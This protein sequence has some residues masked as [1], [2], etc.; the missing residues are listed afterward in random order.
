MRGSSCSAGVAPVAG[1]AAG[2]DDGA[3]SDVGPGAHGRRLGQRTVRHKK[4][5][6]FLAAVARNGHGLVEEEGLNPREAAH[7]ALV[8][9]LRLAAGIDTRELANRLGAELVDEAA[10]ARLARLGL[11]EKHGPRLAAT[12]QGR[13][14]LDSILAEIAA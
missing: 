12:G 5:E 7:E 6:N 9:G 2:A 13:L 3:G 4:P 10:V 8:M 1:A 14:L 11:L